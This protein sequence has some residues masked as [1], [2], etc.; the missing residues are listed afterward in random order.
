MTSPSRTGELLRLA[1]PAI[2]SYML[3]NAPRINDQFWV[4]GLGGAAQAAVGATFFVQIMNFALVFLAVGG[5]LALVARSVGARDLPLRDSLVRHALGFGAGLGLFL[6]VL[7]YPALDWIVR[8]RRPFPATRDSSGT[9]TCRPLYLFLVP[10][11]L[12][13][14]LDSAFIGLGNTRI[15]LLMQVCAVSLN[16]V[17]N[18]LLIY[19][20]Q[21]SGAVDAPFA[22][23]LSQ[24]AGVLGIEPMGIRGAALATGLARTSTVVLGLCL[25]RAKLAAPLVVFGTGV[26]VRWDR[27]HA[28]ARIGAPMS[29]SI[30]F[31][32]GTYWLLLKFVLSRLGTAAVAGGIGLGFQAF[33][34]VSFPCYLGISIA[35][36]SL[37]GR[38]IGARNATGALQVV[39]SARWLG[40]H[41]GSRFRALVLDPGGVP[42]CSSSRRIQKS[43][44][45]QRATST[46]WPS[47]STGSR[48]RP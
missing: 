21:A 44:A 3:N 7:S 1:W 34:G 48:P 45:R 40:P 36:S 10:M 33:E 19:G 43:R 17:L 32:A 41:R 14:V 8:G 38:E 5:T 26:A 4:Q 37:V 12:F 39:R 31:Y 27:V 47:R 6:T 29:L 9:T 18:P 30:A 23:S 15:P 24:L 11:A 16:Y 46:C 25:L 2:C 35:A 13:P 20:D 28:L 22:A 42:S